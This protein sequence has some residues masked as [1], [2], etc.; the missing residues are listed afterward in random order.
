MDI[1][2]AVVPYSLVYETGREQAVGMSIGWQVI[3]SIVGGITV[4]VVGVAAFKTG[5]PLRTIVG[6]GI[7]GLCA[8]AAVNVAGAFTGVSL[9]LNALSGACCVVLGIPGV[10]ALLLEKT[11]LGV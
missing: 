7:Q 9:G 1:S 3:W 2:R 10:I 6:S 8:L 4:I 11:I 5:R